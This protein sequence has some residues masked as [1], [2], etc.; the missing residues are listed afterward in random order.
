M[1]LFLREPKEK[2]SHQF[3]SFLL[4]MVFFSAEGDEGISHGSFTMV[5]GNQVFLPNSPDFPGD[6]PSR[7]MSRSPMMW[8]PSRQKRQSVFST[9]L[10]GGLLGGLGGGVWGGVFFFSCFLG[11]VGGGTG[12]GGG[13]L[14]WGFG[15]GL[16]CVGGGGGG[17]GGGGL[18][19]E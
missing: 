19:A 12:G 4:P 3:F 6:P 5:G 16:F 2:P 8:T 10:W 17:G 15:G 11:G 7:R 18:A 9:F 1:R 14:R 13:F